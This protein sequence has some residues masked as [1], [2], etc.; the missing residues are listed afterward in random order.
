MDAKK[1]CDICAFEKNEIS[2]VPCVCKKI[3]VCQS[4]VKKFLLEQKDINPKCMQCKIIWTFDFIRQIFDKKFDEKYRTHRS[5]IILEREKSLLHQTQIEIVRE[6][7]VENILKIYRESNLLQKEIK[8]ERSLLRADNRSLTKKIKDE[9][10]EKEKKIYRSEIKNNQKQIEEFLS[11]EKDLEELKIKV[12]KKLDE[13]QDNKTSGDEKEK[14]WF[15]GHCPEEKCRGF[16]DKKSLCGL[17]EKK[18][19]KKCR[20]KEHENECDPEI[21]E[22][23]KMISTNTK[24]CPSCHAPIS[25]ISGCDQMYCVLCHTAFS[26]NTGA[27]EKGRIHNPHYY[28]F[29]RNNNQQIR[30][31]GDFRCGERINI[32]NYFSKIREILNSEKEEKIL[33]DSD[34]YSNHIR[35][36]FLEMRY[37]FFDGGLDNADL[38][39]RFLTEKSFTEKKWLKIIKMREKKEKKKIS[40][41]VYIRCFV[42]C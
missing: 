42:M 21:L 11:E 28:E 9:E 26:W 27:I 16:L 1:N 22:T 25:K 10:D 7:K 8:K 15:Y 19:C 35:I 38:R 18:A 17:C 41:M 30:E 20:Q 14:N 4:C 12:L 32:L 39:K 37:R 40:L 34:R 33:L 5:K 3:D 31:A 29:K 23:V 6:K 13:Y 2:F 36:Y 24:P